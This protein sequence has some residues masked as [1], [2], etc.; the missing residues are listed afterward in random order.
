MAMKVRAVRTWLDALDPD[1]SVGIDEGGLRL[2]EINPHG[3]TGEPGDPGVA[4]LDVGGYA[5]DEEEEP[6]TIHSSA[7][8][9]YRAV[10]AARHSGVDPDKLVC[11][12]CR[13]NREDCGCT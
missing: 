5:D 9:E 4:Y 1:G 3:P 10:A 13:G 6:T 7:A 2:V 8:R 11:P 12:V